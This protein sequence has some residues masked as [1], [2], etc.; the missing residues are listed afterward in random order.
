[1]K[2][3]YSDFWW[4]WGDLSGKNKR[5]RGEDRMGV[6]GWVPTVLPLKGG[7]NVKFHTLKD[8]I[9]INES[10]QRSLSNK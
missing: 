6:R 3:A 1:M 5:E 7:V 8:P 10:A 4:K 2:L 9:M